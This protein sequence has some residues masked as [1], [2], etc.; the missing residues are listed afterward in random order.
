MLATLVAALKDASMVPH[1]P[2]FIGT[3]MMDIYHFSNRH[4]VTENHKAR[5]M[6]VF[7]RSNPI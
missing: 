3:Y 2:S 1:P 4:K 7:Y 6:L 5:Y